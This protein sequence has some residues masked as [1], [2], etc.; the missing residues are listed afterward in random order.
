MLVRFARTLVRQQIAALRHGAHLAST[1]V[2]NEGAAATKERRPQP[3]TVAATVQER[4]W[5]LANLVH[6]DRSG[7]LAKEARRWRAA[8][9]ACDGA[10]DAQ[11]KELIVGKYG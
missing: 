9:A 10:H 2:R 8:A 5:R 3:P 6:A 1:V 4:A 7:A 11:L